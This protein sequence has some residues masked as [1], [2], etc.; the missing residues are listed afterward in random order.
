MHIAA[1]SIQMTS[2]ADSQRN[3]LD[4]TRAGATYFTI[5]FRPQNVTLVLLS[6][7]PSSSSFSYFTR[8]NLMIYSSQQI[9]RHEVYG[10]PIGLSDLC[11]TMKV[12][13]SVAVFGTTTHYYSQLG[14]L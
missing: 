10:L 13:V 7:A 11:P 14:I 1:S 3:R 2:I 12:E 5:K 4:W 6:S 9:S 8:F